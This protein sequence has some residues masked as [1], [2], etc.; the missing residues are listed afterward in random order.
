MGILPGEAP[1]KPA[2][3]GVSALRGASWTRCPTYH[4]RDGRLINGI[5]ASIPPIQRT[6]PEPKLDDDNPWDDDRG[7]RCIRRQ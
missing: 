6:C 7:I 2:C 3:E 5:E 4:M 1:E